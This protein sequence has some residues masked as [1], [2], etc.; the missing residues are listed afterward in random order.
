MSR[1]LPRWSR[2][3]SIVLWSTGD[4]L[5][6]SNETDVLNGVLETRHLHH[7]CAAAGQLNNSDINRVICEISTF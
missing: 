7:R 6:V 5:I 2:S 1:S 4:Y 3:S